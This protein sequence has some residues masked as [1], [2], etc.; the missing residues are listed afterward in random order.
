MHA[1]AAVCNNV[2]AGQ[3]CRCVCGSVVDHQC[4]VMTLQ[5]LQGWLKKQHARFM[6]VLVLLHCNMADDQM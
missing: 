2:V 6:F 5:D 3:H 1:Q 4:M